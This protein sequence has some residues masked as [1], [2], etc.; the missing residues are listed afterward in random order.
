M[1]K[2][3]LKKSWTKCGGQA[4]PRPFYKKNKIESISISTSEM[5]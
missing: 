2:K 5:L 3:F 4:N 1:K